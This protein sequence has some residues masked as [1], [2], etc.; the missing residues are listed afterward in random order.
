MIDC[1]PDSRR[2][3]Q[4]RKR[5]DFPVLKESQVSLI[6]LSRVPFLPA[7]L[8]AGNLFNHA[9]AQEPRATAPEP[10]YP[11]ESQVT[12]EW[13]YSCPD[14]KCSFACPGHGGASHVTK[15]TIYL[16]TIP[17]GTLQH[18]PALLYEFS[19]SE[20][21]AANGF[22]INAGLS[23]LSC[24]INGMTVDYSGPAKT[25]FGQGLAGTK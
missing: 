13:D 17:V 4:R 22:I 7:L 9:S 14:N 19:T 11:E 21:R 15:L 5:R 25:S 18:V 16:G 6:S 24:Q 1:S 12:F 2:I 3:N 23:T 20:I 8:I 10:H